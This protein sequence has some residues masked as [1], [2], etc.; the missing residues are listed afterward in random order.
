MTT[1]RRR[2]ALALAALILAALSVFMLELPRFGLEITHSAVGQTPVTTYRL[3]DADG[4]PV[5]VAHG[6]AGSRQLMQAYSLTL[7]QAGYV[8]VAFD[9]EGHG[10]NP[11]PMSGDVTAIDGTTRLLVAQTREVAEAVL[12]RTG[13]VRV[14]FL[15]HSMASD[16]IIRTAIE[17]GDR[18]GPIVALSP[19]SGAVTP[20]KPRNLLMISGAWEGRLRDFGLEAVREVD[21]EAEEGQVV[22]AGD[23]RRA[24][25]VAPGVEHVG[26]LYSRTAL[27]AARDWLDTAFGRQSDGPVALIGPWLLVLLAALVAL[28]APLAHALPRRAPEPPEPLPAPLFLGL[29]LVPAVTVPFVAPFLET[30]LLPVLVAEYLLVHLLVYGLLQLV[31]LRWVGRRIGP[32]RPLAALGLLAWGLGAFGLALD[33]YG[34]N[35]MPD[36]SRLAIIAALSLGAVP[37]M[38]ADAVLTRGAPLW[39]R[40]VARV[41][42][43]GSLI[44]AATLDFDGLFFL[45]LITP[46]VLLYFLTFGLMGRWVA[47][48]A[49]PG[50][51]G[52]ALGLILAWALGVSFP[53]FD[54]GGGT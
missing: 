16:V 50:A 14:A 32:V 35:F 46:V 7:A 1:P 8:A 37:F 12:D 4:P 17:M 38:L 2:A 22:V 5:I 36:L 43:V 18:A 34:A 25:L 3:P 11:V 20:T 24:A 27:L 28:G 41:G 30:D 54:A 48:R 47:M 13:A 51:A 6:F 26:I 53:L 19:F 42:F 45:L 39:A 52:L 29:V 44:L 49:G 10:R 21:P 23:L 33:R 9:F 15:G 40:V 31:L